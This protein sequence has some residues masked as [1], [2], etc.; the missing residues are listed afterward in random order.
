MAGLIAFAFFFILS[1]ILLSTVEEQDRLYFGL[2]FLFACVYS[3]LPDLIPG[4]FDDTIVVAAGA[5]FS[6][7][8][9]IR[10]QPETPKWIIFPLLVASIYTLVGGFIP[11]PVDELL[12]YAIMGGAAAYGATRPVTVHTQL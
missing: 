2:P 5:L 7:T 9:W 4:P 11:L 8:L 3:L 12:V 10:N 1:G 6:F